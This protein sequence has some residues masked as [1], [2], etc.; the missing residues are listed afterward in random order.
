M[1]VDFEIMNEVRKKLRAYLTDLRPDPESALAALL[2]LCTS[3]AKELGMDPCLLCARTVSGYAAIYGIS[4]TE[5]LRQTLQ[6]AL[7][8]IQ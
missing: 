6:Q 7:K 3:Y 1:S 2:V 5:L 8:E 4:H